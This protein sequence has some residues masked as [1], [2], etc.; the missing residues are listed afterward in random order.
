MPPITRLANGSQ[1]RAP[2]IWPSQT[3]WRCSENAERKPRSAARLDFFG[4]LSRALG[5][6]GSFFTWSDSLTG[7]LRVRHTSA[8][9]CLVVGSRERYGNIVPG[10]PGQRRTQLPGKARRVLIEHCKSALRP[11]AGRVGN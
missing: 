5:L 6:H 10:T 8:Y 9:M 7:G 4:E 3:M 1:M 2:E 11:D